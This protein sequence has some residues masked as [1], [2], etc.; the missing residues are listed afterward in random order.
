MDKR[1]TVLRGFFFKTKEPNKIKEW[2]KTHLG[3]NTDQY[4]CTFW[5]KDT[6]GN[7]CSTQWSTMKEDTDYLHPSK[8]TL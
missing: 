3:L 7:D 5:W 4:G 8:S 2:Y 6:S 1:V